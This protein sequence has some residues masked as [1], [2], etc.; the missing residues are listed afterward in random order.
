MR[1]CLILQFLAACFVFTPGAA[2]GDCVPPFAGTIFIDP[3]IITPS[4]PT[5]FLGAT[6]T[7]QGLR[8]VYD[9]R[10]GWIWIDAYLFDAT[11]DD[12]LT[13][14]IQVNPEFG[15]I[16]A[17]E[18]EALK[19]GW[20]VGQL[21]TALRIDVLYLWIHKGVY[22][23]GGG[24]DSILIHTGQSAIYE[25]SGILEEA[26]VHE[27]AHTSLDAAHAA[28]TGWLD[29]QIA[30]DCFISTYARD[31]PL[32]E[33]VAESFLPYLAIRY[34]SDRISQALEETIQQ[35]IPNRIA[36]FDDQPFDMYPVGGQGPAFIRGD[37]TGDGVFN[38]LVDAL[39]ILEFQFQGGEVPPCMESAD[40]DGN[41]V[42]NGLVDSLFVLAHQ[43]Q[44]GPPPSA[45]YPDCGVD[46]DPSVS[47]GC[48]SHP[49]CR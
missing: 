9:R 49:G 24:N 33:D 40:A 29:A 45:P 20:A 41:A 22:P 10:F 28:A 21:P 15:S 31:N 14:E 11:F 1:S 6:Y 44:G 7:G 17:A 36:Y 8:Y 26:L 48:D 13:A 12:G 27:A 39:R 35:A 43:F 25:S 18:I 4:D 32:S 19:Y 37:A 23:F 34:R 2:H 3:D 16:A 5:A 42:F 38:G 46:P 30:D 47:L